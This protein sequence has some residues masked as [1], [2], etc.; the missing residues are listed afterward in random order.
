MRDIISVFKS[1]ANR[2]FSGRALSASHELVTET[3]SSSR[4]G[5][6]PD[7]QEEIGP[8][9][10][11]P[12]GL[13]LALFPG[14]LVRPARQEMLEDV[15]ARQHRVAGHVVHPPDQPLPPLGDEVLLE[16]ARGLLLRQVGD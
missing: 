10:L 3:T 12:L 9:Q 16:A 14:L 13:P 1:Q 6:L 11:I 4:P 2:R 15:T 5:L 8:H 7:R